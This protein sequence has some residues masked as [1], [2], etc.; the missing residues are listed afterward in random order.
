MAPAAPDR[1]P[2]ASWLIPILG[3]LLISAVLSLGRTA[4]KPA[5]PPSLR[6]PEGT[7]PTTPAS[8]VTDS[9]VPATSPSVTPAPGEVVPEPTL[10]VYPGAKLE[11]TEPVFRYRIKGNFTAVRDYYLGHFG[12]KV[13]YAEVQAGS[14]GRQRAVIFRMDS[15]E[16]VQVT[17]T[18]EE[19]IVELAIGPLAMLR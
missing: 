7:A 6:T 11:M 5:A 8:A 19:G 3:I 10:P 9:A 1:I 13:Q 17:A 2:L 18:W 4:P 15:P 16:A 14:D 12:D